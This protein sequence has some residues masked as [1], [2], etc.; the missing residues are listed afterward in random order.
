MNSSNIEIK[1]GKIVDVIEVVDP[2]SVYGDWFKGS[3]VNPE[4]N[5]S[6][7]VWV[8]VA[9]LLNTDVPTLR[10]RSKIDQ[11]FSNGTNAEQFKKMLDAIGQEFVAFEIDVKGKVVDK[12]QTSKDADLSKGMPNRHGVWYERDDGSGHSVV[13]ELC[14]IDGGDL[15]N[16]RFKIKYTCYQGSRV[17]DD[18]EADVRAST[19]CYFFYLVEKKK[20][21]ISRQ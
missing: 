8:T 20:Q 13:R 18:K 7:C 12:L 17:G 19:M 6:N 4:G 1:D 9:A 14:E 2:S 11:D 15:E 3:N 16:R 21:G 5:D 10:Q